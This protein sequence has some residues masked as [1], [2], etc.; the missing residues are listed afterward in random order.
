MSRAPD[1]IVVGGGLIGCLAARAL[2]DDGRRV[3][4]FERGAE[5]GRKASTAAAGM[6]SPQMEWAED[7]LVEGADDL[8]RRTDAMLDLGIAAR[9]RWPA[10]AAALEAETG[11]RLHYRDEGTLVVA[12]TD[13]EAAE[14][15]ARA[16]TQRR[17]GLR[18][19]WLE[20]GRVQELEP[21]IAG[22]ALGALYIPDDR[23]VDPLPLMAAAGEALAA[24]P[25]V[26]IEIGTTVRAI[27]S[28][29]GRVTGVAIEGGTAG[30]RGTAEAE[31]VVLAAGAW[32]A[33]IAGLPRPLAVRP[34]KGQMAALRPAAMPIRHVVG[35]RGAYC[36]PRDDGRIV[37]GATVEDAGFDERVDPAAVEALIR[38]AA[39]AVPA[40]AAAPVE[41][42]WAGLRPGTA[43]DLP[44]L[45]EDPELAGLLYATGHYRNGILLAPLTAEIVAALAR[46]DDPPVDTIPFSPARAGLEEPASRQ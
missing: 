22:A 21:G 40:L 39:A 44:V 35:G 45:G 11:R 3:T 19:E 42:R 31:L 27:V 17:R 37:V 4:L 41:S 28:A 7:L 25:G 2:A 6:L 1:A 8:A 32:S 10:F 33:G 29:G 15:E 14:L 24:R 12:L 20:P 16:R 18:A 43:D 30:E 36:V 5:L 23:Q 13:E 26:R 38:A 9:G 34:V 46:G